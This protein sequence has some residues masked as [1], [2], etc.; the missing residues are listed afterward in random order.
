MGLGAERYW[1]FIKDAGG[2]IARRTERAED[3][4]GLEDE[5]DDA[6]AALVVDALL[7]ADEEGSGALLPLIIFNTSKYSGDPLTGIHHGLSFKYILAACKK[8]IILLFIPLYIYIRFLFY[9][10][11]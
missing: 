11:R 2:A 3:L 7:V 6:D 8:F 9:Y 4:A 10:F 1:V 5:A